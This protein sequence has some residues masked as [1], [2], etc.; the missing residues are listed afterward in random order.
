MINLFSVNMSPSVPEATRQTLLSGFIGEGPQV[1]E[2]EQKLREYL[3]VDNILTVNSCTSALAL[4]LDLIDVR[5]KEVIT[6]PMTCSATNM[7]IWHAGAKIVWADINPETGLIDPADVERK[8]T[9]KTAAIMAV[10]WGGQNCDYDKL[11][12]FGIPVIS[13]AAHSFGPTTSYVADYVCHSFQAIKFLT[14][15]DGGLLYIKDTEKYKVARNLRWF[16]INRD[17]TS[18]MRGELDIPRPGF[19][20]HMNDIAA[21]IGLE[22]LNIIETVLSTHRSLTLMYDQLIPESMQSANNRLHGAHWLYTIFSD[23]SRDLINYLNDNVIAAGKIHGRNDK[24]SCFSDSVVDLPG[25]D[26]F[27]D[28]ML[29]IPMNAGLNEGHVRYISEIL[30]KYRC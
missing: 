23:S 4:A 11:A 19:K 6:T 7:P 22:N 8:I 5:G 17:H 20:Y 21:T 12:E 28:K 10:N 25:V 2:F 16:G 9:D 15:G 24:L 18:G 30:G 1:Q 26:T 14:T 27:F 13:D 3:G 29:C